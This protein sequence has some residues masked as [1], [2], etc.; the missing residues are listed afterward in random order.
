MRRGPR[1]RTWYAHVAPFAD[2]RPE[3]AER[4]AALLVRAIFGNVH[5]R[6]PAPSG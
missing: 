2:L 5:L 1:R 6:E 3:Q 4:K